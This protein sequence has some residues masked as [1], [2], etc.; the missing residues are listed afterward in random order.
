MPEQDST[1]EGQVGTIGRSEADEARNRSF[2]AGVIDDPYPVY[3]E[4]LAQCPVHHGGMGEPFGV[5]TAFDA[6]AD[7]GLTTVYG[8]REVVEVLRDDARFSNRWY[9]ASLNLMIG[10][11]ML[12]MDEPEH[13]RQRLLLQRAFSKREMR[14]WRTDIVEPI[15]NRLLDELAPQGRA[16]LYA[17][18]AAFIPAR[19]IV[20]ALGLPQRD[21]AE[22]FEWAI[23]MTSSVATPE[24]RMAAQRAMAE[25]VAPLCDERRGGDGRDLITTLVNA[26][27]ADEDVEEGEEVARHPLS[28]DEING[29]IGLLLVG[30]TSTTYRAFGNLLHLLLTHPDQLALLRADRSLSSNAIEESLRLEQPLV[31]WGRLATVD[32]EVAGV[33]VNAGC[34]V[35]VNSG[36]AN[37][38][39]REW[40]DPD[41]FDIRRPHPDRHLTFGFGKHHCLGVH[42]A[43]MELDVML[44]AVLDRLPDLHLET[45]D[46]VQRTGLGFR[47]VTSLPCAWTAP[48]TT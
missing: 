31:A 18:F 7:R 45:T 34:P 28:T 22:F 33:P 44:D 19:V 30:G 9:D 43:R 41:A 11:N 16:D 3:H 37:H 13:K 15:V 14:W 12:G 1:T 5:P 48:A 10:P 25:Y 35:V 47:M 39:P 27:I 40:P 36:A 17:D 32:T 20:E 38:D 2:G 4:L 23:T 21:L 6:F 46:G 24:Q 26:T 8:Y 42:L 29:A